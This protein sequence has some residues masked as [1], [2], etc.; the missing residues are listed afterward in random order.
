MSD[1]STQ[2]REWAN[3][4]R[5]Q[6]DVIRYLAAVGEQD[7]RGELADSGASLLDATADG[8]D[9]IADEVE[10][11]SGEVGTPQVDE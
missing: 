5:V 11:Q 6:A 7:L 9:A 1:V 2:I 8:W 10:K 3:S 4:D